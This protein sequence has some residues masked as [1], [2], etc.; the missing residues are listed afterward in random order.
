M[1]NCE[2]PVLF[3]GLHCLLLFVKKKNLLNR[4]SFHVMSRVNQGHL[5]SLHPLRLVATIITLH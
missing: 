2:K 3:E 5:T 1:V 4:D